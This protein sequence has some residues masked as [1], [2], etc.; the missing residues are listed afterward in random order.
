[1]A[2][3]TLGHS[4]GLDKSGCHYNHRSGGY[5]CHEGRATAASTQAQGTRTPPA[6]D[7]RTYNVRVM[8]TAVGWKFE[9]KRG[10]KVSLQEI[11]NGAPV[12]RPLPLE[13]ASKDDRCSYLFVVADA[14]HIYP[15]VVDLCPRAATIGPL[16]NDQVAAGFKQGL[17]SY[18]RCL[19]L[20]FNRDPSL[21]AISVRLEF[22][23]KEDGRAIN[24]RIREER[25]RRTPLN[26][27]LT[28][29]LSNLEWP[30]FR[31]GPRYVVFPLRARR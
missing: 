27:C 30:P 3:P 8:R 22:A 20:E 26:G 1:M 21:S 31:G 9:T 4:G 19:S 14:G 7:L 17:D 10:A 15:E 29:A 23:I 2:A 6:A 13:V 5:H 24:A 25:F 11:S 16:T 18:K 12:G 28:Q